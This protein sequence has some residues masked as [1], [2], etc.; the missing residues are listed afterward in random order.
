[1]AFLEREGVLGPA[2]DFAEDLW[3]DWPEESPLSEAADAELVEAVREAEGRVFVGFKEPGSARAAASVQVRDGVRQARFRAVRAGS[4]EAGRSVVRDL[5]GRITRPYRHLPMVAAVVDPDAVPELR[6]H[7]LVNWVEP[8]G[9]YQPL[10]GR[11]PLAQH[12]PANI[13]QV[14]APQAW[15]VN[16]GEGARVW[17]VDT[18]TSGG[19]QHHADLPPL[20]SLIAGRCLSFI[21]SSA[22]CSDTFGGSHGTRVA[23]VALALDNTS[24]LVGVAPAIGFWGS[25][26]VCVAFCS[27]EYLVDALEFL[28][29]NGSK[30]IINLS[31]GGFSNDVGVAAAVS[32]NWNAGDLMVGAAGNDSIG[33]VIYPAAYS[34]VIA[35]SGTTG[36]NLPTRHPASNFGPEIEIAAPFQVTTLTGTAGH[37]T[38]SGTSFSTPAVSGAAALVWTKNPTWSTPDVRDQLRT[39]AV[40]YGSPG[41]D[42]EFGYGF[43]D[44]AAAVQA[45]PPITVSIAGPS[46][47]RSGDFC[48][49]QVV[50]GGA[51]GSVTQQW[52]GVLSGTG[53]FVNG[54]LSSSGTLFVDV[55]TSTGQQGDADLFITVSSSAPLCEF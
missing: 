20:G 24:D 43:L 4:I 2:E 26:K 42:A 47:V 7:R 23:G 33:V 22:D 51:A 35:V 8:V 15:A 41:V 12:V 13:T 21:P 46:T 30:D 10:N 50:V 36:G 5:G 34:Q 27:H 44:A 11:L 39:T 40:D 48:S 25:A 14:N 19:T 37:S 31:L 16:R 55:Q 3:I 45:P 52:S 18:G 49:W 38:V 53:T 54:S 29:L 32:A 28:G 1:V 9:R 6:A 17:V